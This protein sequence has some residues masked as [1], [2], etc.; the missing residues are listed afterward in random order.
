MAKRGS[1]FLS[2]ILGVSIAIALS[3]AL[4]YLARVEIRR[5]YNFRYKSEARLLSRS[6]VDV[7]KANPLS[8]PPYELYPGRWIKVESEDLERYINI[9]AVILPDGKTIDVKWEKI[10]ERIFRIANLPIDL[11][12]K[13][14][15]FIDVDKDSRL[16]G[17][18]GGENLNRKIYLLEELLKMKD[19]NRDIYSN[20]ISKYFTAVSNGRVNI[21]TAPK[22]VLMALSDEIDERV[23]DA[24]IDFREKERIEKPSDLKKIPGFPERIIPKIS[25]VICFEGKYF[26][27]RIEVKVQ[28]AT[29]KT[30]AVVSDGKIIYEKEGW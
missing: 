8:I 20:F 27:I 10:F 6:I 17:Y 28:E 18:E 13:I 30:E 21:N 11:I 5:S 9:N 14:C 25:E 26:R 7:L 22:E 23:A 12:P 29:L 16:G 24:I 15:D 1:V 4:N 3:V 2:V 19:M